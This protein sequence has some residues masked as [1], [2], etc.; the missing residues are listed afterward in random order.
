MLIPSLL[1]LKDELLHS[2]CNFIGV[3]FNDSFTGVQR[4]IEYEEEWV[5]ADR[6]CLGVTLCIQSPVQIS[7]C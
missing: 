2:S 6:R 7:F 5:Y 3:Y 4:A 1:K